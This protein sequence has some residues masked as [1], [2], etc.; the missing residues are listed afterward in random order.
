M[1]IINNKTTKRL[2]YSALIITALSVSVFLSLDAQE[3]NSYYVL[4]EIP[5]EKEMQVQQIE[6]QQLNNVDT[7]IAVIIP[8]PSDES[9]PEVVPESVATSETRKIQIALIMDTSGSMEGLIEQAKS[10]LW[11]LVGELSHA[12][13]GGKTPQLEIAL[14]QYGN[15]GLS[16]RGGYIQR[17]APLVADLDE[18]S[19]SLFSL[20]T[21]GGSEYCGKVI[22]TSLQ[23]LEWSTNDDD[24]K[25]IFIAGNEPFTQG[26][27]S[28]E[29]A[30]G[31][32]RAKGVIVNTIH[33]GSYQEGINGS[34][35]SGAMIGGGDYMAIQQN[36]RTV[37]VESPYDDRINDCGVKLNKTYIYYGAKGCAKKES[38]ECEDANASSY[39]KSNLAS[40]NSLKVSGFYNSGSW[41]LVDA[42]VSDST[43]VV[44]VDKKTLAP[45]LQKKTDAE[46]VA[47]VNEQ[48]AIRAKLKKEIAELNQKRMTYIAKQNKASGTDLQSSMVNAVKKQ[49]KAKN[50]SW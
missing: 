17:I 20:R 26:P 44:N 18:V 9:V 41:D 47:Y 27:V 15:D 29:S 28:Y 7:P 37:Y 3:L 50:Y 49:A 5:V 31:N 14:Y 43:V 42:S 23:Q 45:E 6:Y 33:C 19:A 30:C 24:I 34:W 35:K 40:R 12:K 10:Q 22:Q 46:L 13:Y 25:L 48:S 21:N 11:N 4:P 38:Q 1:K 32:A 36:Q 2:A 8:L 16:S 39:S